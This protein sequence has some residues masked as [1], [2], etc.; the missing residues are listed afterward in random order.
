MGHVPK[1]NPSIIRKIGSILKATG[2]FFLVIKTI[3]IAVNAKKILVNLLAIN[4]PERNENAII[5]VDF[6]CFITFINRYTHMEIKKN[7]TPSGEILVVAYKR[8][9]NADNP[10]NNSNGTNLCLPIT[11]P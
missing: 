1:A 2:I 5:L 9:V 10:K 8:G 4:I 6:A 7:D 11:V 3:T